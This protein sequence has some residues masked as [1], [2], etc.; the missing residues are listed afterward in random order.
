MEAIPALS[1][2]SD[3]KIHAV[4]TADKIPMTDIHLLL[5][6]LSWATVFILP[7]TIQTMNIPAAPIMN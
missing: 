4:V 6:L 2:S 1:V 7:V 3:M 5:P